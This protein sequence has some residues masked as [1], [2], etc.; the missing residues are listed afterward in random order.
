MNTFVEGIH[1]TVSRS[2]DENENFLVHVAGQEALRSSI[3]RDIRTEQA[4]QG[5]LYINNWELYI[6]NGDSGRNV[7]VLYV[8]DAYASNSGILE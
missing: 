8:D 7:P 5:G 4:S 1:Q 6:P 2:I 3:I